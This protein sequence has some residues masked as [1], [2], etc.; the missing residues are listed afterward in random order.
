MRVCRRTPSLGSEG[1]GGP[2]AK[3]RSGPVWSFPWTKISLFVAIPR[4]GS[5]NCLIFFFAEA[6]SHPLMKNLAESIRFSA[7]IA[8]VVSDYVALKGSGNN[9]K[10]LCPFHSEK[11]PS[12]SVHREKQIFHCFGCG[13]GGDVFK[14]V[15]LVEQV[16]FPE[17]IRIV[18]EKCGV[19]IPKV[20]VGDD[21]AS[22]EREW[23]LDL[24]EKAGAYFRKKLDT[25]EGIAARQILERREIRPEFIERF[26]LGYAP[27]AGLLKLLHPK[28]PVRT[29]LFIRNDRGETY[30][31]FRRRLMFPIWNERG[32]VI[33]FGGRIVGEGNPKYL[34]SPESALYSKSFVLYGLHLAR[35]Q[36][37]KSGRMVVVEGYFDCLSLHQNGVENVVAS[38]GTSLTSQ[39]VAVLSRY[40][41]EVIINYDPDAA[42]QSAARR[43]IELLLERGLT[44]RILSLP[45]GLDPDDYVRKEGAE[46]YRRQLDGAPYFWEH[47]IS[48]ARASG[49]LSRPEFKSRVLAE[50][51]GYASHVPDRVVQL[52]VA[53]AIAEG[54]SLPDE[55]VL[56]QLRGGRKAV[57]PASP[58]SRRLTLAEKQIIQALLQDPG[59][60]EPLSRFL[61]NDFLKGVWSGPLLERLIAEPISDVENALEGIGDE[62]LQREVRAA[63]LEPFGQIPPEVAIVSM[64]QLYQ[65]HL[66]K[67]EKEIR[68]KLKEY[69]PG[70]APAE[71]LE[72]QMAIATE[73]SRLK[74]IRP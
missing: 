42:G 24:N 71:L 54:F 53:R 9:L 27:P 73:K 34:N 68:E 66:V 21:R 70:A 4:A 14:F 32:K 51:A 37:R 16:S 28:D 48:E 7:D 35:S 59:I 41:P 18:A 67:K 5:I 36:A 23:L 1:D 3:E 58:A 52:E 63:V 30:D 8:R 33:A 12:F 74:A 26:G 15:M 46:A 11:T 19:P 55:L 44:V 2:D 56:E 31:R 60:A 64:G 6:P 13:V 20:S 38:C 65:D 50:I 43:S 69:G 25:P 47:L 45:G 39:Q 72:K 29:G 17:S 61:E 22:R 57:P 49:D 62:D 40:V 10:G